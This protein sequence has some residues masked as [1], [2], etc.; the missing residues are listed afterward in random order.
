MC[1]AP[2]QQSAE[3]FPRSYVEALRSENKS[4]RAKLTEER[5][6]RETAERERDEAL[7]RANAPTRP[8]GFTQLVKQLGSQ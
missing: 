7:A 8:M 3:M 5:R 2:K 1:R 6:Q 4:L